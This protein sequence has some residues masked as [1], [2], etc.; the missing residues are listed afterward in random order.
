MRKG[1]S[2]WKLTKRPLET[3]QP[4]L[5]KQAAK[6][7]RP[8]TQQPAQRGPAKTGTPSMFIVPGRD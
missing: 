3:F 6:K 1:V 8:Y 2:G 4:E 7:T 5:T